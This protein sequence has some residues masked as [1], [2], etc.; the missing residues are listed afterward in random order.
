MKLCVSCNLIKEFN[1][2]KLNK[3]TKDG[4]SSWCKKCHH[5][6]MKNRYYLNLELSRK[7]NNEKRAKRIKWLQELKSNIPC[8]DCGKIYEPYCMDYDHLPDFKKHK[9]VSRMV[10]ENAPKEKILE[11]I[12]KCE[13]V[14]VLCHNKRTFNRFNE[15]L[16]NKRAWKNH[17]LRNINIINSFKSQPCTICNQQYDHFNMQIDH[18]DPKDKL[19]DV[20]KLKSCKKQTLLNELEKCQVVCALCHRKKSILEQKQNKYN[21][22]R[23]KPNK[24]KELFYDPINHKKECGLCHQIK[25][26]DLFIINKKTKS[27]LDTYCRECFNQYRINKRK[28]PVITTHNKK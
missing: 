15:K 27:G 14:C 6:Y 25:S 16:G 9:S 1:N 18:I 23:K 26:S 24:R 17:N 19:Y 7:Y 20:C 5:I 3:K 13:L 8:K 21:I 12:N 2:F 11:E 28:K 22:D 4:Y 10:L